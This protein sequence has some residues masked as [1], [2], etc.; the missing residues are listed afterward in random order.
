M[1]FFSKSQPAFDPDKDVQ[2]LTGKVVIV[3]GGN[4]GIG[5][6]TVQHLARHGAKV[7]IAA[8]S[9]PKAKAAVERLRAEGLQP[10]NGAVDWFELDL[11]DPRKAK[12]SAETFLEMEKRLDI[13][14]NNAGIMTDTGKPSGDGLI[15]PMIVNHV[16]PFVFTNTLL[17]LLT[18]T[19]K[20]PDSDVRIVFVSTTVIKMVKNRDPHF[21]NLEDLN[22]KFGMNPLASMLRYGKSKLAGALYAK[23]LQRNLDAEGIPI[24]VLALHPGAVHTEGVGKDPAMK[25]PII[26]PLANF[27]FSKV[28]EPATVGAYASVFAAGSPTV[29]AERDK[30]K[31]AFLWPPG[32]LDDPP[33]PQVE[34]TELAEEVWSTTEKLL[35]EWGV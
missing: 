5:F 20:E 30:Y 29:K 7:Y 26:G 19:A 32:K 16:S 28:F 24:T 6:A 35:K 17:P 8:R 23:Q 18:Q 34:S 13:L 3:T 22:E 33:A 14:V 4:S 11:S 31:G 9:E 27:V 25:L 12:K 2:D 21:R 10:G 1:G 15:E